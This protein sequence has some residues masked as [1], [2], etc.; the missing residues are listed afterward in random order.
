MQEGRGLVRGPGEEEGR[1]WKGF[2]DEGG[3]QA[4]GVSFQSNTSWEQQVR[5]R[6]RLALCK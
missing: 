3:G 5:L 1:R 2:G 6:W 4:G